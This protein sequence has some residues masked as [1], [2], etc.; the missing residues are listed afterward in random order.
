MLPTFMQIHHPHRP[1][2]VTKVFILTQGFLVK[3]SP[4]RV[5]QSDQFEGKK[6]KKLSGWKSAG[7]SIQMRS[8]G[9]ALNLGYSSVNKSIM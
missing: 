4:L 5:T 8:I 1:K 2:F 3:V 7:T 6:E 9:I